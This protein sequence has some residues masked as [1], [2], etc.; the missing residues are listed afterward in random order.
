M[1]MTCISNSTDKY[2]GNTDSQHLKENSNYGT[3]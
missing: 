2:Y 3:N 1:A